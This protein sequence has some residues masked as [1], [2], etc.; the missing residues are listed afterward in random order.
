ME[1]WASFCP[2]INPCTFF[3]THHGHACRLLIWKLPRSIV[4]NI[5]SLFHNYSPLPSNISQK[6]FYHSQSN[7]NCC[8]SEVVC[9]SYFTVL[10][11]SLA[12]FHYPVSCLLL[13]VSGIVTCLQ[14][15][16]SVKGNTLYILNTWRY[17]HVAKN[18]FALG[19]RPVPLIMGKIGKFYSFRNQLV[20]RIRYVS[21][22]RAP[23]IK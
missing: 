10:V 12:V 21:P 5:S 22:A 1:L 13:R 3:K 7:T 6:F 2:V 9:S 11:P 4:L 18:V 17:L 23:R 15:G 8:N 19:S 14:G 20:C 16:R